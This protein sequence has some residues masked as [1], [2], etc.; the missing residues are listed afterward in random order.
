MRLRG[1]SALISMTDG[2]REII[3]CLAAEW[4]GGGYIPNATCDS[5]GMTMGY[6]VPGSYA[7]SEQGVD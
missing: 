6:L 2:K 5:S 1:W 7:Y 3:F 4:G